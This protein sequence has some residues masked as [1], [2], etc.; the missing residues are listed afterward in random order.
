MNWSIYNRGDLAEQSKL[1]EQ[2]A[3]HKSQ[4][5][6]LTDQIREDQ[7]GQNGGL[8]SASKGCKS[9]DQTFYYYFLTIILAE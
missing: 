3:D 9:S 7:E 5:A 6:S 1:E 2:F 8:N 4:R